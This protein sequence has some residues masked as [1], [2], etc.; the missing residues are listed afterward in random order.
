MSQFNICLVAAV[1]NNGCIGKNGKLPWYYQEDLKVFQKLTINRSIIMG[2]KTFESI[3]RPLPNRMNIVMTQ[4][5][6]RYSNLKHKY[7]NIEFVNNIDDSLKIAQQ[8]T[9]NQD[10]IFIIGGT[11]IY[12]LFLPMATQMLITKI[13]REYNGDSYFPVWP[14]EQLVSWQEITRSLGKNK[15]LCFIRYEKI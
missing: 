13:N 15:D 12:S 14:V 6:N 4:Y 8:Y 1:S 7:N 2:R 11:Q 5:P 10:P 3:A 9:Y